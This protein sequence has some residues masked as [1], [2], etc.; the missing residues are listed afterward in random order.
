[1]ANLILPGSG[2]SQ[3]SNCRFFQKVSL[4]QKK[5]TLIYCKPAFAK[6]TLCCQKTAGTDKPMLCLPEW[7]HCTRLFCNAEDTQLKTGADFQS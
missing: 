1:M 4:F 6:E 2:N 3:L 7:L 5:I